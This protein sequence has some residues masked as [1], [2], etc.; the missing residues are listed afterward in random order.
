MCVPPEHL[1]HLTIPASTLLLSIS[2]LRRQDETQA[3]IFLIRIKV[4]DLDS[5]FDPRSL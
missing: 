2:F 1:H 4:S 3:K 5:L